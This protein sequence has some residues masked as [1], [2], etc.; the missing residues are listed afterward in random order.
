MI[1]KEEHKTWW[2][3]N[4]T[5]SYKNKLNKNT[6]ICQI[7]LRTLF[8]AMNHYSPFAI[9]GLLFSLPPAPSRYTFTPSS[10]PMVPWAQPA[11]LLPGVSLPPFFQKAS[12]QLSLTVC[13]MPYIYS[14]WKGG[15]ML[16]IKL[17]DDSEKMTGLFFFLLGGINKEID[18]KDG[19]W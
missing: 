15:R 17:V 12:L 13:A 4:I 16:A 19:A 2:L 9:P 1:L 3:K 11:S 18:S 8:A 5:Y 6:P 7:S 14:K 10:F